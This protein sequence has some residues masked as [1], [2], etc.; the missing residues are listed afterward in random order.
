MMRGKDSNGHEYIFMPRDPEKAVNKLADLGVLAATREW[1][2]AALVSLLV[3]NKG[4][5]RPSRGTSGGFNKYS[6][7]EFARIGIYG[8]CSEIIV[9][10]Y[11]RIWEMTGLAIPSPGEKVTLPSQDFPD[12]NE[13]LGRRPGDEIDLDEDDVDDESEDYEDEDEGEE[14]ERAAAS[15]KNKTRQNP[16]PKPRPSPQPSNKSA[17]DSLLAAFNRISPS[18]IAK[19]ANKEQVRVFTKTV[20]SW[21]EDLE[22]VLAEMELE[23]Y[24]AI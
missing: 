16:R 22:E 6:I 7:S 9:A 2:R 13:I 23:S 20:K 14:E 21:L 11:L 4:R 1:E 10:A 19:G 12:L 8:F 24:P 18:E 3:K 17:I 15:S 5:G